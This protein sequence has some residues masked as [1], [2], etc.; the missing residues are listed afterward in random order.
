[1]SFQ[2]FFKHREVRLSNAK[3]D[4]VEVSPFATQE[5]VEDLLERAMNCHWSEGLHYLE[6]E[7]GRSERTLCR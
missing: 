5:E 4:E 3:R 7:S 2:S 6:V 1:M